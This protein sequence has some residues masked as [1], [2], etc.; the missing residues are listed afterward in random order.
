MRPTLRSVLLVAGGFPVSLAPALVQPDLWSLW[1]AYLLATTVLIAIDGVFSVP[2]RR[3]DVTVS[4]PDTLYIGDSDP[5]QVTVAA[6][7]WRLPA[8]IEVLAD[9]DT[10]L[11]PQPLAQVT[12]RPGEQANVDVTLKPRRRG[13][14]E[15]ENLWLRWT[16][17][18]G[19]L[20]RRKTV[21][22]GKD[23]SVVPNVRAVRTAALRL[24]GHKN[25]L[26]G[27]KVEHYLGDGSEF[28]SMREY[29]P[30]L[31]H[32]A[33]SWKAS[34]RHRK[35][36]CQEFRAERNHQVVLAFDT[37]H[38][39]REPLGG[40]A[41]LD[42]A[43]N[44]GLLLSYFCLRSGDR[45]GLFSFDRGVQSFAEPVGGVGA[46]PRLQRYSADI[47][48]STAETNFTL[49][50][51]ELSTRLRRRSMVVLLT[52]FV[53]TITAELMVENLARLSRKHVVVFVTLRDPDVDRIV[54]QPPASLDSLHRSVVASDFR[55]ERAVVLE[56]LRQLGI[57]CIDVAPEKV[58]I[59]LLNRY[60]DIKR[61]EL[62]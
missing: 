43:V 45:V 57:W 12:V 6:P 9:L 36:L 11:E 1:L 48:Y 21:P 5:M 15:L 25:F 16:G 44:A 3:V 60:L 39:M 22:L 55:R 38:L 26:A 14:V 20:Q 50:L 40:I 27:L 41:K 51:A 56:R 10:D 13:R 62:I 31:D 42:H 28:E 8:T 53:D 37:G 24:F 54:A 17:P 7:R 47:R 34:A 58:S 29:T 33:I 18:F 32:R 30:G 61:R 35:L 46:F 4:A 19:L 49:G 2:R 23:V 52:D 59:D